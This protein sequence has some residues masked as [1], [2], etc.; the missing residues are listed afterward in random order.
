MFKFLTLKL[1]EALPEVNDIKIHSGLVLLSLDY[2]SLY[3]RVY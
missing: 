3:S 1:G 2:S